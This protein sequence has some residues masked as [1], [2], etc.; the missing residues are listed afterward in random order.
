MP[1]SKSPRSSA[2]ALLAQLSTLALLCSTPANAEV[3]KG[4]ISIRSGELQ[5]GHSFNL[6]GE[7]LY[8]PGYTLAPGEKPKL[9]D[10]VSRFVP[11][12]VPQLLN[13]VRWWLDDSADFQKDEDSRLKKLGFDTERAEDGWYRLAV[14]LP[15]LPAGQRLFIEFEGVAMKCAAFCN[16]RP[17]GDHT[18]MFSRFSF[19]LTPHLKP[20]R[21]LL[22]VFVSMEKIP[23]SSLSMG[24]AVTV[25]LTASKVRS[26]SKGMYGPLSPG[27]DNR[28]YDLH[29]IWQ[30]VKLVVRGAASL[31]DVWFIPSPTGAEVRVEASSQAGSVPA[32]LKAKWTEFGPSN[33]PAK[34][35][36][37]NI[38][39][40]KLTKHTLALRD[41]QPKL[42]TPANPN[43]Y[44]L[45]VTLESGNEILDSWSRNVGFRTFE[46]RGNQLLLNGK[47]YWLRGADHLPYGKNPWDPE[48]PRK[49]I[50]P[51]HDM[52]VRITRT[53]ATPWNEAWLN[54]A[55]EIGLGVSIEGIRPWALAGKIGA[56]PTNLFD[57]W[58]NENED[59]IKRCRNH[60]SVLIYTVGNEMLLG[61]TKNLEKWQQLSTVVKQTRQL[62]PSRPVIASSEYQRSPDFYNESLKPQGIDDGDIDDIHR[63]NNWYGPSSFVTNSSFD[64]EMRRNIWNRPLIGQEMSSGYPD[65][66]T[67]LPVLRYTRDLLTPQAWVGQ[68]A[69]PHHDPAVF[70]EHHRAVTK[71]WAERLRVERGN[72]TA[73]FMLFAAE[74]WFAHSYDSKRVSPYPVCEAVREAWS[75]VGL[76]LETSRRRFYES[77]TIDS[78]VFMTNDDEEYRN[79][80]DLELRAS[81]EDPKTGQQISFT[82]VGDVAMLRYYQTIKVPLH[83]IIPSA[84]G[85]RKT[86]RL[87]VTLMEDG[88]ELSR[89][90]EPIEIFDQPQPPKTK[91][92][93][94]IVALSLG[95][96]M[97]RLAELHFASVSYDLSSAQMPPRA[98]I[99]AGPEQALTPLKEGSVLRK[100]VENGATAVLLSPGK[101]LLK[102]F[103]DEVLDVKEGEV[104]FA[105]FAPVFGTKLAVSIHPVDI[106]WWAKTNDWRMFIASQSHRLKQGGGARELL[107]YIP[108][109]SYIPAAKLPEQYRTVMFEIPMGRGRVWICDLDLEQ[110]IGIDPAARLFAENLLLAAAD[111]ASTKHLPKVPS[112]EELL[113][114]SKP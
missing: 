78:A 12:P 101:D 10:N 109:H 74:C 17:L 90:T 61:D 8:K 87:S 50:H 4:A 102:L 66:D 56:T 24:E 112:H 36:F 73:G 92:D 98:V 94:P 110:S 42:W 111:P 19:D 69:Y 34:L 16:G 59:V 13:R 83:L 3:Q 79:H 41:F 53:H 76:A 31:D 22:A 28:A 93:S 55:D 9:S 2:T 30:P 7:W 82:S 43:L 95:P 11:V 75:P 114:T 72:K 58:L 51:L 77:E 64:A 100:W 106:K 29:G 45:D 107:R 40:Q 103:P 89:T 86:A 52:N 99:L 85:T 35:I 81:I 21:N 105:D 63:Y 57:H 38:N 54:A 48:L 70:L 26:L 6:N 32:L 108:P 25:N 27:F 96:S 84:G 33:A 97:S 71:R 88:K 60:P 80:Y 14:D 18:G 46:V 15:A 1:R 47:P 20:G 23:P 68:G 67:G 5:P 65:L 113:Q 44:R 104:E 39:V 49:L 91:I 37:E 62:D